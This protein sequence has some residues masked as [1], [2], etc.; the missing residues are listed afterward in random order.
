MLAAR[1]SLLTN[2]LG[3]DRLSFKEALAANASLAR[4]RFHPLFLPLLSQAKHRPASRD[5]ASRRGLGQLVTAA[6]GRAHAAGCCD[7]PTLVV[8]P[9]Q[10]VLLAGVWL[11]RALVVR[12]MWVMGAGGGGRSTARCIGD[13]GAC[14]S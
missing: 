3:Y 13:M 14:S 5:A 9:D 11:R 7:A 12:G 10:R 2:E 1:D 8:V 4:V 6:G